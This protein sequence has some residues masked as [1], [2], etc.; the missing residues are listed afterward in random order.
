[1]FGRKERKNMFEAS[2]RHFESKGKLSSAY[3]DHKTYEKQPVR[4]RRVRMGVSG[5]SIQDSNFVIA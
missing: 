1:M 4:G 3:L 5:K 2:K